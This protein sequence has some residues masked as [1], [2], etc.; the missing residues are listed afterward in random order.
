MSLWAASYTCQTLISLGGDQEMSG[1][2]GPDIHLGLHGGYERCI[3][4]HL[5][6]RDE[7]PSRPIHGPMGHENPFESL[8]KKNGT[9]RGI[10]NL[11]R[12]LMND[13][14]GRFIASHPVIGESLGAF[15]PT[16]RAHSLKAC[17]ALLVA[18]AGVIVISGTATRLRALSPHFQGQPAPRS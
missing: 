14:V 15:T 16:H 1:V 9:T 2:L 4:S 12:S 17:F 10:K 3:E 5:M 6:D 18:K 8:S 7:R 13:N 11:S